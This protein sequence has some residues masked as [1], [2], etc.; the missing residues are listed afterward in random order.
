MNPRKQNNGRPDNGDKKAEAPSSDNPLASSLHITVSVPEEIE[1]KMVDASVLSDYEIWTWI[2]SFVANF[3]VGFLVAYYQD[4]NPILM[5]N[6]IAFGVLLTAA[7]IVT[8]HKR[9][10]LQCKSKSMKWKVHPANE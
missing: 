6:C 4:P 9:K 8:Y 7:I 5:W 3:A 1:V 10:K 2:S